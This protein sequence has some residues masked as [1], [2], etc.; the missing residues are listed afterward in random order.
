MRIVA[1]TLAQTGDAHVDAAIGGQQV[2]DTCQLFTGQDAIRAL[3][4]QLQQAGFRRPQKLLYT[5]R[6]AQGKARRIEAPALEH[7]DPSPVHPVS[8]FVAAQD[9]AHPGDQFAGVEGLD[10]VVVGPQFQPEDPVG[11]HAAAGE[12]QYATVMAALDIAHHVQTVAVGQA[13]IDNA[14]G[15]IELAQVTE[16]FVAGGETAVTKAEFAQDLA[17][18]L[19]HQG[20]IFGNGDQAWVQLGGRRTG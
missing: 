15:G 5:L 9:A 12:D 6:R 3:E 20:V 4:Q 19:G 1:Q 13:Q 10:H 2:V 11:N 16:Q 17:Q 14:Q 8:P 18:G 7:G